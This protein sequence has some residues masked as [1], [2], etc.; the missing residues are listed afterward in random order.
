[1]PFSNLATLATLMTFVDADLARNADKGFAEPYV[2]TAGV[3]AQ[4]VLRLA[5][6]AMLRLAQQIGGAN[7]WAERAHE[8]AGVTFQVGLVNGHGA[9]YRAELAKIAKHLRAHGLRCRLDDD[10]P[11]PA[12]HVT[13]NKHLG[14]NAAA[15]HP[16]YVR[17]LAAR[18]ATLPAW[19]ADAG[20]AA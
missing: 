5:E 13:L 9:P 4:R 12:L 6:E 19:A 8:R 15:A 1:M 14:P 7:V 11:F 2:P 16:A 3:L 20:K 10:G 17:I 18:G